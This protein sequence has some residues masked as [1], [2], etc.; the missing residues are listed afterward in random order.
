MTLPRLKSAIW[1][2]AARRN[3]CS[4]KN[5]LANQTSLDGTSQTRRTK[6]RP[7][8]G[9]PTAQPLEGRS[10]ARSCH[11]A[12]RGASPTPG[13]RRRRCIISQPVRDRR[14]SRR[15]ERTRTNFIW[16]SAPNVVPFAVTNRTEKRNRAGGVRVVRSFIAAY[17]VA[18]C[19]PS[20]K[21]A[22]MVASLACRS[23][24]RTFVAVCGWRTSRACLLG[25]LA[26]APGSVAM[27]AHRLPAVRKPCSLACRAGRRRET[28]ARPF[29]CRGEAGA[30]RKPVAPVARAGRVCVRF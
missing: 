24:V 5:H 6:N 3:G 29:A 15:P 14:P 10:P 1:L 27:L 23:G 19:W 16:V 21:T 12:L 2:L 9:I 13:T 18:S 7:Y 17:H 20:A 25:A 26:A 4:I 11:G 30:R 28:E 8:A 22:S